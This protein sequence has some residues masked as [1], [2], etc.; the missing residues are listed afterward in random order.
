MILSRVNI[1][2]T[3]PGTGKVDLFFWPEPSYLTYL[4]YPAIGVCLAR[5]LNCDTNGC[6]VGYLGRSGWISINS[7]LSET[8]VTECH[9][10]YH[11]Q[12]IAEPIPDLANQMLS[13]YP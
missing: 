13:I 3:P 6:L 7:R 8:A 9:P 12:G 1:I 2:Y 5:I 4:F 10:S 11:C